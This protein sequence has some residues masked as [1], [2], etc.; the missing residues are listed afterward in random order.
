VSDG[1]QPVLTEEPVHQLL[2]TTKT[3]SG[4]IEWFPAHPHEG[5]VTAAVPNAT[6]VY[7]PTS[8]R[9][10][11]QVALYEATDGREGGTLEGRPVVIL[12]TS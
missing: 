11:E 4:R 7:Q 8:D 3:A 1:Y 6:N 12:T 5:G 10:H 2:R 9:V